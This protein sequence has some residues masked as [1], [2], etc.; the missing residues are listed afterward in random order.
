M[1]KGADVSEYQRTI[2]YSKAK[3]DISF[4]I[5]RTGFAQTTDKMFRKNVQNA[6]LKRVAVPAVY[7]FSYAL[8]EEDAIREARYA[9]SE[10]QYVGLPKSTV[11]FYDFEYDSVDY[12]KRKGMALG[13]TQ[14][15]LFTRSFCDEVIKMG[16]RAGIYLNLDYYKNMYFPTTLN[17]GKYFIWLADWTGGPDK[18]CAIQQ[19]T[20]KGTVAGIQGN[21]D[22]NYIYDENIMDEDIDPEEEKT[23]LELANE[24]IAGKWGFGADRKINLTNAGY[25]YAKVQAKVNELLTENADTEDNHPNGDG[26]GMDLRYDET[27][28]A[29]YTFPEAT[30][31]RKAPGENK[32]ATCLIPKDVYMVCDGHYVV[33]E[34][35][36]WMFMSGIPFNNGQ[37]YVGY[38]PAKNAKKVC[39]NM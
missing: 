17:C 5:P 1:L 30:Y 14:C 21:V 24:V 18:P 15:D 38:L 7:H 12:G 23:L 10:C 20:S 33:C 22:M 39:K 29:W 9:V 8:C 2:D 3:N 4:I 34:D 37:M 35:E 32:I 13:K 27:K 28:A 19:Y 25:D 31:M 36:I 16:Y 26:A 6:I 11:I